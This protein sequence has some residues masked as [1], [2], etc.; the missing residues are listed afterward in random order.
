M[1]LLEWWYCGVL[2]I[3]TLCFWHCG[4]VCGFRC[5]VCV[6]RGWVRFVSGWSF[7]L[8]TAACHLHQAY[9]T[10]LGF[11]FIRRQIITHPEW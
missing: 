11:H 4:A 8:G 10:Y 6:D 2:G 7:G 5:C 9:D 1:C 3:F